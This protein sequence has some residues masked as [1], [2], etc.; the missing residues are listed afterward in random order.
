[1][2]N[3][4]LRLAQCVIPCRDLQYSTLI[5]RPCTMKSAGTN[6]YLSIFCDLT[7]LPLSMAIAVASGV[8]PDLGLYTSIVG[9]FLVSAFGGSRFQIAD[10]PVPLLFSSLS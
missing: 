1:M 10:Q 2:H 7:A 3:Q 8:S 9:G 4:S 6:C 5:K